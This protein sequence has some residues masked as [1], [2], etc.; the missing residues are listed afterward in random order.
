ME[1]PLYVPDDTNLRGSELATAML[2]H[3]PFVDGALEGLR[4]IEQGENSIVTL[5][6]LRESLA[7]GEPII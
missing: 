3:K 4:E 7:H 2:S 1:K 5:D 6:A